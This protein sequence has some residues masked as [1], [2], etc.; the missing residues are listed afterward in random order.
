MIVS[1]DSDGRIIEQEHAINILARYAV[2]PL[3]SPGQVLKVNAAGDALEWGTGGGGSVDGS[4][5]ATQLAYWS[6]SDTLTSDSRLFY[7][8]T[9]DQLVHGVTPDAGMTAT[10][11]FESQETGRARISAL[12]YGTSV[13]PIFAGWRARGTAAS[14]TAVQST[15]IIFEFDGQGYDGSAWSGIR[16]LIQATATENWD[17]SHHGTTWKWYSTPTGSTTLAGPFLQA[18]TSGLTLTQSATVA[19][20]VGLTLTGGAHTAVTAEL[21]DVYFNLA[22]TVTFTHSSVPTTQRAIRITAP[23][24]ASSASSDSI[25]TAATVYISGAPAAGSNVTISTGLALWVDSGNVQFDG[26]LNVT[27]SVVTGTITATDASIGGVDINSGGIHVTSGMH[28]GVGSGTADIVFTSSSLIT[29]DNASLAIETGLNVGLAS[30]A[31]AGQV[32]TSGTGADN[33]YQ[34]AD[35]NPA[36]IILETYRNTAFQSRITARSARGSLASPSATSSSD[37]LFNITAQGY[38]T[39]SGAGFSTHGP[40]LSYLANQ[41]FTN[42]AQGTRLEI[43]TV[44]NGTTTA[45]LAVTIGNDKSLT[46][47]GGGSYEGALTVGTANST[48][49]TITSNVIDS[50][51][52]TY[53]DSFVLNRYT[54]GTAA[55]NLGG[56]I[57]TQIEDDG[58]TLRKAL[59]I[60][61]RW[62]TATAASFKAQAVFYVED[63][64]GTRE[65][66]RI[67]ASGSAAMIGFLGANAAAKQTSGA[68]LT[69]NVTSGGTNDTI[70]NYTSLTTYSTDAA[71]IRNNIYQLARKLKQVNDA[72]RTYGLLT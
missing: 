10:G 37:G 28:V 57:K 55:A 38:Q 12:G 23:T 42:T 7:N 49:G 39:T 17:S 58:G 11:L 31:G 68:N 56:L 9:N 8:A 21:H 1:Y 71:A 2:G 13:S 72:L 48:N 46:V 67:E 41:A 43:Y 27:S 47:A 51:T 66:M 30:S 45:A 44:P 62:A 52:T 61:F 19:G 53:L 32:Y 65:A 20:G 3:G 54:S 33:W 50:G 14:P 18:D 26:S 59:Q 60:G 69:N 36:G 70:A 35:G 6:D 15:D 5:A 64:A 40:F 25:T 24:Y 34:I 29:V 16:A 22:R 4:G 63:S